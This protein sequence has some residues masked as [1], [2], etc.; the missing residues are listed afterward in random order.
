MTLVY[1]STGRLVKEGDIVKTFR[2]D[3]CKVIKMTPPHKCSSTGLIYVEQNKSISG[4]YPSVV[5]AVWID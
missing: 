1:E 3:E 2:G 5:G 4:F